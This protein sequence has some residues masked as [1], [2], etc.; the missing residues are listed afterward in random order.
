MH[1]SRWLFIVTDN[2]FCVTFIIIALT[3]VLLLISVRNALQSV[4][5]YTHR[6][7]DLT[8]EETH[9]PTSWCLLLICN[10]RQSLPCSDMSIQSHVS[11]REG[12][13][14]L[15]GL[16]YFTPFHIFQLHFF[17]SQM[18]SFNHSAK[19]LHATAKMRVQTR[20]IPCSYI[21]L[22]ISRR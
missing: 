1:N 10:A 16:N 6:D 7:I 12:N 21:T 9:D 14:T 18:H 5:S 17:S 2:V 3:L 20:P 22:N 4:I 11:Y 19:C 13:F 15:T 8:L